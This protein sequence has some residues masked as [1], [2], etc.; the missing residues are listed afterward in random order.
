ME[1]NEDSEAG[2]R[3]EYLEQPRVVQKLMPDL[4][5]LFSGFGAATFS[6][7]YLIAAYASW[8]DRCSHIFI[9][10][11]ISFGISQAVTAIYLY[12]RAFRICTP[13]E[14]THN[15]SNI[16]INVGRIIIGNNILL[17]F[18]ISADFFFASHTCDSSIVML[19]SFT[20]IALIGVIIGSIIGVYFKKR[21]LKILR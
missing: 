11:I 17:A 21:Y 2:L 15:S 4:F 9:G 12:Y 16:T 5:F 20:F 8:G 14:F 18:A 13:S 6:L 7:L 1:I 10:L 3:D 19:G